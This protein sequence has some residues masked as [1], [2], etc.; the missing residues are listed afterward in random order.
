MRACF[1]VTSLG[2]GLLLAATI[3]PPAYAG[4]ASEG[5]PGGLPTLVLLEGGGYALNA[6][7][8]DCGSVTPKQALVIPDGAAT[9]ADG[10]TCK[11]GGESFEIPGDPAD[12]GV[13]HAGRGDEMRCVGDRS[14]RLRHLGGEPLPGGTRCEASDETLAGTVTL[15]GQDGVTVTVGAMVVACDDGSSAL[16]VPRGATMTVDPILDHLKL[17]CP[18]ERFLIRNQPESERAGGQLVVVAD[19]RIAD[20]EARLNRPDRQTVL[21][22]LTLEEAPP[23]APCGDDASRCVFVT[24]TTR[25]GDFGLDD[26]D[27]PLAFADAECNV[28]A[29]N[30]G[31]PGTYMAWLSDNSASPS[32]RFTRATVPY[33]LVNGAKIADNWTDLTDGNIDRTLN[34]TQAGTVVGRGVWTSTRSNGESS[35]Q[36]CGNWNNTVDQGVFGTT[37]LSTFGWTGASA[38]NI[39]TADACNKSYAFYCFQQ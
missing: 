16:I 21:F 5:C 18:A 13:I 10:I 3:A 1:A 25:D 26:P 9:T 17:S 29:A 31:L 24:S 37:G 27:G 34:R 19:E 12:P 8:A 32:T 36:K 30:A 6:Y 11:L 39:R 20:C 28:L 4:D 23:P 35:S 15:V 14:F 33:N 38:D 22:D 7:L 2:A